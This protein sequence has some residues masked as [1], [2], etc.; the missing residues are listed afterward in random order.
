MNPKEIVKV[1]YNQVAEA[2]EQYYGPVVRSPYRDW[3]AEFMRGVRCRWP[4]RR[5][6][7]DAKL[8]NG[9]YSDNE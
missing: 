7:L 4:K 6:T 1:G 5:G 9:Y 3:L 8:S 2:Y